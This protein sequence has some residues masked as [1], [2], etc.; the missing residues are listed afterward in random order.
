MR[1][2][3]LFFDLPNNV[4]PRSQSPGPLYHSFDVYP[5]RSVSL[6]VKHIACHWHLDERKFRR[7]TLEAVTDRDLGRSL[8]D[9]DG[10]VVRQFV[11]P[12]RLLVFHA[13][14]PHGIDRPRPRKVDP[15]RC[16]VS[17]ENRR[18]CG[19]SWFD[20]G[21]LATPARHPSERRICPAF[22][23][24]K[25]RKGPNSQPKP[26]RPSRL[27]A[28]PLSVETF[29]EAAAWATNDLSS[30]NSSR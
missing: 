22:H 17:S 9:G 11:G 21:S 29:V 18:W 4:W 14:P 1:C 20:G 15:D 27:R 5:A 26:A 24:E 23:R 7:Y 25:C 6:P 12:S 28:A 16:N 3:A 8:R 19:R 10:N 13:S 2:D 30:P